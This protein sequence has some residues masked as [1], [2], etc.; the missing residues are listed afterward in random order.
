[1]TT[2]SF[3]K[4]IA[5]VHKGILE[6]DPELA[7]GPGPIVLCDNP[8]SYITREVTKKMYQC[9]FEIL[10][11]PSNANDLLPSHYYFFDQLYKHMERKDFSLFWD[12]SKYIRDF[13]SSRPPDFFASGMNELPLRW[14]KCMENNGHYIF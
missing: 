2:C 14:K 5:K 6:N 7:N 12:I 4:H 13:L 3:Y 11:Y 8:H 1:M 9:G 10:P